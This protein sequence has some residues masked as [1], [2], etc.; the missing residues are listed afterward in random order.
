MSRSYTNYANGLPEPATP[1]QTDE[2]IIIQGGVIKRTPFEDYQAL[3]GWA[4][5]P[6][7]ITRSGSIGVGIDADVSARVI[8][9]GETSDNTKNALWVFNSDDDQIIRAQNDGA[10]H[11]DTSTLWGNEGG[12]FKGNIHVSDIS[13]GRPSAQIVA[14]NYGRPDL[15]GLIS[16]ENNYADK[17][18]A[19]TFYGRLSDNSWRQTSSFFQ[20]FVDYD[21]TVGAYHTVS[22]M[23][24]PGVGTDVL[25]IM[26]WDNN[27]TYANAGAIDIAKEHTLPPDN[28]WVFGGEAVVMADDYAS[29]SITRVDNFT[30]ENRIDRGWA[31]FAHQT[32][33]IGLEVGWNES[34]LTSFVTSYDRTN[35]IFKDLTLEGANI[36]VDILAGNYV[37]SNNGNS[38]RTWTNRNTDTT[39]SSSRAQNILTAGSRSLTLQAIHDD[40]LYIDR[41]AATNLYITLNN[42]VQGY[43]SSAGDI[44]WAGGLQVGGDITISDNDFILGTTTGA[45]LGTTNAQKLGIWGSTPIVQPVSANQAAVSGTA[46]ATYTATE[47]TMINDLKTLANQLRSDLVSIGLIKGSA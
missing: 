40:N 23:H 45:K 30:F 26:W 20:S 21:N 8:I 46:G 28:T 44:V 15:H 4:D 9:R 38:T 16:V 18:S 11:I 27:S 39:N 1:A 13:I 25:N 19:I 34:A 37:S 12:V 5:T 43:F 22:G 33:N 36:Y 32:T 14:T 29:G 6:F 41:T 3:F 2:A 7:G 35:S 10:V 47:Q 31:R 42:V 24:T 17:E